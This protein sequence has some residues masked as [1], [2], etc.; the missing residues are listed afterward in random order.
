MSNKVK[1]YLK[2]LCTIVHNGK[3]ISN[4]IKMNLIYLIQIYK[5]SKNKN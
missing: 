3:I 5:D 4:A 1:Y 2:V